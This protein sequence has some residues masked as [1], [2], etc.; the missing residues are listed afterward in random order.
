MLSH[1]KIKALEKKRQGN[2]LNGVVRKLTK[3]SGPIHHLNPILD[4]DGVLH[5]ADV[6][7]LEKH[8][9]LLPK[10]TRL[11]D[12]TNVQAIKVVQEHTWKSACQGF[13]Y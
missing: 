9:V 8:A 5:E 7:Y 12:L 1:K 6:P 4:E 11:T 13:G 3:R 10:R 2:E